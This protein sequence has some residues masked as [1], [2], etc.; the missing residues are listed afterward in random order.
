[1]D[2]QNIKIVYFSTQKD[3]HFKK[4]FTLIQKLVPEDQIIQCHQFK[5]FE[6]SIRDILLSPGLFLILIRDQKELNEIIRISDKLKDHSVILV[7]DEPV[8]DLTQKALQ[9]YPRYI[10]YIKDG[11]K[12]LFSVIEKMITRIQFI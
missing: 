2:S 4:I 1:M 12:D 7:F 9:L 6:T 11:Y 5:N 10:S 8:E 3:H